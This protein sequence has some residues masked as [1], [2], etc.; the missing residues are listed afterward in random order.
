[1]RTNAQR[2]LVAGSATRGS[3]VANPKKL[4]FRHRS[5]EIGRSANVSVEI[6]E[7][8]G[9]LNRFPGGSHKGDGEAN[10]RLAGSLRRIS[11]TDQYL[12]LQD[13]VLSVFFT[14][15]IHP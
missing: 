9:F 1:M 7:N 12:K 3:F 10:A 5:A 13:A 15:V 11:A 2:G 4:P 14:S 6:S 8:K